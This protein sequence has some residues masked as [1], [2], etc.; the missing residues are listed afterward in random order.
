MSHVSKF[1]SAFLPV[2]CFFVA[3]YF[4][5]HLSLQLQYLENPLLV[6]LLLLTV[7]TVFTTGG[8][9]MSWVTLKLYHAT[10]KKFLLPIFYFWFFVLVSGVGLAFLT[11][12]AVIFG[13]LV[14]VLILAAW[15]MIASGRN[16]RIIII[17]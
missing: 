14:I 16:Q 10:H 5:G 15:F 8:K 13:G 12:M 3:L 11:A 7:L 17:R 9:F 6:G 4:A 2:L 1:K